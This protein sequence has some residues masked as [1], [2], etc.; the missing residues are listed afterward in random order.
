MRMSQFEKENFNSCIQMAE[1]LGGQVCSIVY[2]PTQH[3]DLTC[4]AYI[5][6]ANT[7]Y[8]DIVNQTRYS[9]LKDK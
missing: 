1:Y 7:A 3:Q 2:W 8:S 4:A 6:Q 5:Q 9:C